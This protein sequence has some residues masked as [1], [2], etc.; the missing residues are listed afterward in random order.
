MFGIKTAQKGFQNFVIIG[1]FNLLG[2]IWRIAAVLAGTDEKDLNANHVA[3]AHQSNH[4]HRFNIGIFHIIATLNRSQGLD[5]VAQ[6]QRGFIVQALA[7][8]VHLFGKFFL[9]LG[10]FAFQKL[11]GF[12]DQNF[13]IFFRDFANTRRRTTLNLIHQARPLPIVEHPVAARTQEK[14]FLHN[15]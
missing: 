14:S 1:I 3:F 2:K 9:Q 11:Y 12:F 5:S 7:R 8:F 13:I 10:V 4:I 6:H 15:V